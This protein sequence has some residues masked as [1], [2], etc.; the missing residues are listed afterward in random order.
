MGKLEVAEMR[1]SGM[2]VTDLQGVFHLR[3]N[4]GSLNEFYDR[5]GYGIVVVEEGVLRF[6][7]VGK[8]YIC[9]S[10]HML[11]IPKGV[12][13]KLTCD[14][15]CLHYTV[16]FDAIGSD[17]PAEFH[18]FNA[19]PSKNMLLTL[20]KLH[21]TWEF[22]WESAQFNCLGMLYDILARLSAIGHEDECLN[23]K[24]QNILPSIEYL[25][26]HFT[27]PMITNEL[28]AEASNV[29]TVYFRKIFTETYGIPP[30]RYVR[31]KRIE[32]AQS[33]LENGFTNVSQI[34]EIVGFNSVYHF[35]KTFKQLIG[36]SPTSYLRLINGATPDQYLQIVAEYKQ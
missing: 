13:Y 30:M 4:V 18:L 34:A 29:S 16:N 35:S 7:S 2:R 8:R 12:S 14:E 17:L 27:D 19:R 22:H 20:D 15:K 6:D 28:I 23:A 21:T 33:L 36:V 26:R 32:K 5:K 25:E 1:F 3:Q 11:F 9:D 24:L 10:K 31:Q